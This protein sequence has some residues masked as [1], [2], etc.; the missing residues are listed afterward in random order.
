MKVVLILILAGLLWFEWKVAPVRPPPVHIHPA[1]LSQ[2]EDGGGTEAW[3]L[4]DMADYAV[5]GE[6]S[7]FRPGRKAPAEEEGASTDPQGP[8]QVEGLDLVA[9]VITPKGRE[10]WVRDGKARELTP[11]KEGDSIRGWT[12]KAV[13]PDRIVLERG[14]KEA[15]IPLLQYPE[16]AE[17]AAPKA[18]QRKRPARRSPLRRMPTPPRK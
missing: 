16:H 17:P 11:L 6:H 12:V 18:K 15:R 8:Q 14:P 13:E 4:G 2:V 5:I 3:R 1:P 7:L 9:V 10:A